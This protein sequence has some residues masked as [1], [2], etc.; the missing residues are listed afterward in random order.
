[1]PESDRDLLTRAAREAG[2]I[3]RSYVGG[4]LNVQHKAGNAGPVTAADYAVNRLL[5]DHLRTARPDYGWL[6]EESEDSTARQSSAS[7]FIIDPIDG[8]RS[9][10]EGQDTWAHSLAVARNGV[11]TAAAVFLPELDRMYTA[12]AGEGATFNGAP[13]QASDAADLAAAKVLAT[14]PTLDP[15]HWA[16]AVPEIK[17]SHR[18]SLAYR[19]CLVAQGR[20]DLMLTFRPSWEWDIAAGALILAEAGAQVTDKSGKPL[21]FNNPHPQ[22]DGVVAGAPR[23]HRSVLELLA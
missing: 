11:V 16:G 9:F 15:H 18:P 7:V 20:F 4:P 12:A 17:R 14:K 8:T 5:E 23:L 13:M 21:R 19:M 1:M 22:S 10:I 3:A 2:K 6:S